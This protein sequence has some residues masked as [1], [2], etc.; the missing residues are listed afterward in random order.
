EREQAVLAAQMRRADNH[1]TRLPALQIIFDFRDPV[2]IA[3]VEESLGKGW[4]FAIRGVKFTR[5]KIGIAFSPGLHR[6]RAGDSFA[7]RNEFKQKIR[8]AL[9]IR[10]T[11]KN[12]GMFARRLQAEDLLMIRMGATNQI[13]FDAE[14]FGPA[15]QARR[16]Q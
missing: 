12:F 15:V 11:G 5:H 2:P 9:S 8:F 16:F 1:K 7:L 6:L 13:M 14:V 10:K 4:K 3:V